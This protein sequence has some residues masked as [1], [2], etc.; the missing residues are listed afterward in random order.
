MQ[1]TWHGP[2][3]DDDPKATFAADVLSYILSQP[4]SKFQKA[5]V[6]SGL[7]LSADIGYYTQRHTGPINLAA[8]VTPDK[9]RDAIPALLAE[10]EQMTLPTYYSDE[11]LETA[12]TL[13]AIQDLYGREVMSDFTHTVSFW[14][15][16][17][18]LDYYRNY[19]QNLKSVTRADINRYLNE[20]V[21]GKPFVAGVVLAPGG[22][23]LTPDVLRGLA[24]QVG[25][26]VSEDSE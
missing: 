18:S 20:Y 15:A 19:I 21:Y 25:A 23:K 9:L 16:T 22:P 13:L 14:W 17:A 8:Q 11:Q 5:L 12:K 2:S 6:E 24:T 7:T 3:V 4:A 1:F 10:L 26:Q